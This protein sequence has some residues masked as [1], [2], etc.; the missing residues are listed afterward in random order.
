[1]NLARRQFLQLTAGASAIWVC[2]LDALALDYP[3]RPVRLIVGFPAAS[4]PDIVA[5]LLGQWLSDQ[6]GQPFVIENMTG[7][8]SG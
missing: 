1:M 2:P 7:A 3:T 6:L 8:G 5:R 4:G